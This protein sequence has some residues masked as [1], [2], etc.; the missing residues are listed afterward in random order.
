M[1]RHTTTAFITALLALFA[2][3]TAQQNDSAAGFQLAFVD[4]QELIRAHPAQAEIERLGQALDTELQDLIGQ[5]D[6]LAAKSQN[7][8]L[9]AE[10]QELLQALQVTIQTRRDQGLADIRE[11]AAPAEQA[12]NEIIREIA[13]AE[14][15]ELVLDIGSASGL[16]VYA[17]DGVPDITQA[18][19]E[20][21]REL[22]GT[23][24]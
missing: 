19:V 18:A 22:H 9:T 1:R 21:M 16:V 5:R 10:E 24:Q 4:T 7:Q 8:E 12:A 13:E 15:F 14:G 6:A 11:A 3:A 17:A 23:A 20:R 2:L